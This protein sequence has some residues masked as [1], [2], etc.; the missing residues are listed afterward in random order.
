MKTNFNK[1]NKTN[2]SQYRSC[3]SCLSHNF[4][5]E[6]EMSK[7]IYYTNHNNILDYFICSFF[8]SFLLICYCFR[9]TIIT[10]HKCTCNAFSMSTEWGKKF[11]ERY[12]LWTSTVAN[13]QE[14]LFF[15]DGSCRWQHR[16][17]RIAGKQTVFLHPFWTLIHK[18]FLSYITT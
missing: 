17:R 6:Q 5:E 8:L 3:L 7:Q 12:C 11:W 1:K 2:L 16:L 9:I 10:I 13:S 15:V 4:L 18:N 14:N